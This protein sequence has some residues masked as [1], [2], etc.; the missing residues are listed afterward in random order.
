MFQSC[1]MFDVW[2][3]RVNCCELFSSEEVRWTNG[4][5]MKSQVTFLNPIKLKW[6]HQLHH[7]ASMDLVFDFPSGG[8]FSLFKYTPTCCPVG[9]ESVDCVDCVRP[10]CVWSGDHGAYSGYMMLV[11]R[12]PPV[13]IHQEF[14]SFWL[15]R[16]F[17]QECQKLLYGRDTLDTPTD[18][19]RSTGPSPL[20]ETLWNVDPVPLQ[21]VF[22]PYIL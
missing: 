12:R 10:D 1:R 20:N 4:K 16:F 18:G 7:V 6:C 9:P 2:V 19:A 8:G 5:W 21:N 11:V 13:S 17:Y 15:F 3:E 22:R 14:W